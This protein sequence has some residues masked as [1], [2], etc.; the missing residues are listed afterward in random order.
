MRLIL[1]LICGAL[2]FAVVYIFAPGFIE[3]FLPRASNSQAADSEGGAGQTSKASRQDLLKKR[4]IASIPYA[5]EAPREPEIHNAPSRP[6][7][8][9]ENSLPGRLIFTVSDETA[10]LYDTNSSS[11]LVVGRLRKGDVVEPKF[12]LLGGGQEWLFVTVAD[13]QVSGFLRSDAVETWLV[14]ESTSR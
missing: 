12:R 9:P 8:L 2:V 7:N 14:A 3:V 13:P 5:A 6:A 11:G 4:A 10:S 1:V